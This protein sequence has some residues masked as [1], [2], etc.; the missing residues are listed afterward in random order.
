[1]EKTM[2]ERAIHFNKNYKIYDN[3]RPGYPNE[4]YEIISKYR[5]FDKNSDILEIG[6]GN[7]V[8][9]NEINNKWQA[10]LT[11]LEPGGNFCEL[12]QLKFRNNNNVKIINLSFEKYENN[13]LFDAIFSATAFHWL[14]LSIKYKKSYELLKNDGLLILFW[15]NYNF[16]NIGIKD[17]IQKIYEKYGKGFNDKKSNYERQ[18]EKIESRRKEIDESNYFKV[19][20]HKIIK[21]LFEYSTYEYIQLLKTFS[22]HSEFDSKFWEE[23]EQIIINNGNKINVKIISNLEI[24]N[25][26]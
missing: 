9:S 24:A 8:A 3:I 12:L 5:S 22:D 10:N 2:E 1:M 15:N 21:N 11:L 18:M 13:E 25:K 6:A 20:E 19:I 17:K 26:L 4:I 23:M 16:E 14:D 7:G